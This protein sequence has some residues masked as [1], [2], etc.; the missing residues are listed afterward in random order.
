QLGGVTLPKGARV[1]AL[2][3]SA[4]HDEAQFPDPEVFDPHRQNLGRHMGFGN[5]NHF[6]LGAPLARLEARVALEALSTRLP[7]LRLVP[8]QELSYQRSMPFLR[9]LSQLLVEWDVDETLAFIQ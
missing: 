5:G 2:L 7:S 9:A 6:C 4:N 1:I 3:S 8:N